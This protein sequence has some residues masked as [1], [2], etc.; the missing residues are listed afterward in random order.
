[1]A[2]KI[3]VLI[4]D[5]HPV[6]RQGLRA[7]LE[8]EEDIEVVGEVGDGAEA[9]QKAEELVPD[10]VLMDLAMPKLD[11]VVATGRIKDISPKTR[12]LVLTNYAEDE[13]VFGAMKAGA[14]GYLLKDVEPS[15]LIQAVRSTH[16]GDPARGRHPGN[17]LPT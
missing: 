17:R 4:A 7:L 12:V 1:M 8:L 13:Q 14:T 11:G 16:Q 10:V 5:D 15:D 9:V 2:D 3:E 6:V